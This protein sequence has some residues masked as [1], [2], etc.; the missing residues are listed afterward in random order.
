MFTKENI[1]L[2]IIYKNRNLIN[3]INVTYGIIDRLPNGVSSPELEYWNANILG[4]A[5]TLQDLTLMA[6][7]LFTLSTNSNNT[8]VVIT[9]TF[10]NPYTGSVVWK[11]LAPNGQIY[12]S[13]EDVVNTATP[14][15]DLGTDDDGYYTVWCAVQNM[16]CQKVEFEGV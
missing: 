16:G 7:P 6:T 9:A 14:F 1:D 2:Y 10:Q 13:T 8:R 11:I 15:L 12:T 3:Q 4:V 5:P